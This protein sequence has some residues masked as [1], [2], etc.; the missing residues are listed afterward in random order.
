MTPELE[1]EMAG[2]RDNTLNFFHPQLLILSYPRPLQ[3]SSPTYHHLRL[4]HS[5]RYVSNRIPWFLPCSFRGYSA[6]CVD[7]FNKG[8]EYNC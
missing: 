2:A 7:F 5:M 4:S 3:T 6:D 1:A 8:D